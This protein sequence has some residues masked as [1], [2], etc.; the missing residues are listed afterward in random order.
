M[1]QVN[2]PV[3]NPE[4]GALIRYDDSELTD[5]S[6]RRINY[7]EARL[8]PNYDQSTGMP[9]GVSAQVNISGAASAPSTSGAAQTVSVTRINDSGYENY[10]TINTSSGLTVRQIRE[11]CASRLG[12]GSGM[13]AVVNGSQAEDGAVVAAGSNVVFKEAA[14]RRG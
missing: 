11:A 9:T 2:R 6:G 5:A 4:S 10:P 13:I 14:K 3:Y 1:S 8:S 12:L 7:G